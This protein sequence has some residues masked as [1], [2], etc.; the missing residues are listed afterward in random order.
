MEAYVRAVVR[1][2]QA[3]AWQAEAC[4]VQSLYLGGGTP[5]LL[6]CTDL[7]RLF[8]AAGEVF[9]WRDE[10]EITLEA[11]PDSVHSPEQVQDWRELGVTRV[12]LGVQSLD[13]ALLDFLGRSHTL[14]QS[15][16]AVDCLRRAGMDNFGLDLIWGIPG[17]EVGSWR[18]SVSRAAAWGPAHLSLYSLSVEPH[19]PLAAM[20][21][22]WGQDGCQG[23]RGAE[24]PE[25]EAWT[26]MFLQGREILLRSGF[27]HYEISNFALPGRRCQH[28]SG[29]W[30]GEAYLGFG[31]A[32]VSSLHCVRRKN[33]DRLGDYLQMI[34]HGRPG[35]EEEALD[36]DLVH[37][38]K[39]M[40]SMRTSQG[41]KWM[42]IQRRGKQGFAAQLEQAGLLEIRG[43]RATLTPQGMLVSNEI[44][45]R[46]LE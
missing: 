30:R 25:E 19:T 32:A 26:E 18:D 41:M 33:P 29:I 27:E 2:M 10:P 22:S 6:P 39:A 13:P 17:Q 3:R 4:K 28:N 12:S 20:A 36:P 46:L 7:E 23:E 40:L 9:S 34:A 14:K 24:W 37:W 15:E 5:S 16:A 42:D 11:N 44:L 35:P 21:A 1:E 31:P 8:R 38:E 45:A 43:G